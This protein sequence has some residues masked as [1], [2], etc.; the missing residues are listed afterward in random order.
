MDQGDGV[1]VAYGSARGTVSA[2]KKEPLD[3]KN[4]S[5]WDLDD[6]AARGPVRRLRR[7][8]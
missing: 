7:R 5:L 8:D 2:V 4:R 6:V 3:D 1:T